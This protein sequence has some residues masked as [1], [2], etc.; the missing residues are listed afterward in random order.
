MNLTVALVSDKDRTYCAGTWVASDRILT[1]SHCIIDEDTDLAADS[2]HVRDYDGVVFEGKVIKVDRRV[3]LALLQ[4][5]HAHAWAPVASV[6]HKGEELTIIGHPAGQEWAW[7]RGWISAYRKHK[8]PESDGDMLMLQIQAPVWYG[9][10]G[11]GAF[12]VT[13]ALVGVCS[14]RSDTIPELGLFVAPEEIA[15]FLLT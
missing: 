3:D 9:N 7:M 15:A 11:G 4:A 1:A 6:W 13:G 10:S 5:P 14:L 12:D 8:S 2:V